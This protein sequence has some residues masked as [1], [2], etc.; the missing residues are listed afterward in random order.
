MAEENPAVEA[1]KKEA[2]N[3]RAHANKHFGDLRKH[4]TAGLEDLGRILVHDAKK[5]VSDEFQ[6]KILAE[7]AKSRH[8]PL[9]TSILMAL[10]FGAG[11][12]V[13][14]LIWG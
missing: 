5:V 7:I 10:T 6:D 13:G 4:L 2:R 11:I 12:W 9:V 14:H 8:T 1:V 3:I